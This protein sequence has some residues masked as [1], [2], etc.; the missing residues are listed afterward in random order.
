MHGVVT[1]VRIFQHSLRIDVSLPKWKLPPPE[2]LGGEQRDTIYNDIMSK[3][4]H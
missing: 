4:I 1:S 2:K 3:V